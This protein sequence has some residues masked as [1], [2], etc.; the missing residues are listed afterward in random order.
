MP[1][2]DSDENG[3]RIKK[4]NTSNL[5]KKTTTTLQEQQTF[6]FISFPLMLQTDTS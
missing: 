5:Q 2:G 1:N 4:I 6:L 3:K